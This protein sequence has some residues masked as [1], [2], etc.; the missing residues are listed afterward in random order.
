MP[1]FCS[2][3]SDRVD[4]LRSFLFEACSFFPEVGVHAFGAGRC[5]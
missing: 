3:G 2:R 4:N 1:W 5:L